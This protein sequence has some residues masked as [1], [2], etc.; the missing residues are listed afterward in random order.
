MH[1]RGKSF[2]YIAEFPDGSQEV[3][4]D[5]PKWDFEWQVEYVLAKPR[6][7]PKGTRLR[8]VATYDNSKDN[9]NNPDPTK[10][11]FFGLQSTEE[12]MIGYFEVMWHDEP[13]S[14]SLTLPAQAPK[15]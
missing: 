5:V 9:K 15:L 12:M 8:A 4:L 13:K 1:L 14:A 7:L 3:L 10:S 11:V 2:R 6:F